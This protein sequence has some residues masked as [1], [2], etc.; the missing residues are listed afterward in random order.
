MELSLPISQNLSLQLWVQLI[1]PLTAFNYVGWPLIFATLDQNIQKWPLLSPLVLCVLVHCPEEKKASRK[2]PQAGCAV[3]K[4]S[5]RNYR[6]TF[7]V[8][9]STSCGSV[10]VFQDMLKF[11]LG[12]EDFS[13]G[14]YYI[15]FWCHENI[16]GCYQILL[17][18]TK[19]K[20]WE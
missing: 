7:F 12:K 1:W 11:E 17:L 8:G 10:S 18:N 16:N 15:F 19:H 13:T 2:E 9:V 4:K 6:W 3:L 5:R 20:V 14:D